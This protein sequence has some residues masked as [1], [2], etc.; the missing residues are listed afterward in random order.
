MKLLVYYRYYSAAL[1]K[2]LLIFLFFA[3]VIF[4]PLAF[5]L[6][7]NDILGFGDPIGNAQDE[8]YYVCDRIDEKRYRKRKEKEKR[9][10][11]SKR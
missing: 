3:T 6:M 1:L 2:S 9:K 11:E 4:I 8:A 10:K 7:D 5:Y